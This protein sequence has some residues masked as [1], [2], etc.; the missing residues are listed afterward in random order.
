[1]RGSSVMRQIHDSLGKGSNTQTSQ[2][3]TVSQVGKWEQQVRA[4][5]A[6][7]PRSK[8]L[9]MPTAGGGKTQ[10]RVITH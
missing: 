3:D 5:T 1:M 8:I 10:W 6:G 2:H 7:D 4:D 9:G